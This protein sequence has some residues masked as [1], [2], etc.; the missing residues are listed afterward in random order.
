MDYRSCNALCC[1]HCSPVL[2]EKY[3]SLSGEE[4]MD[5]RNYNI[6]YIYGILFHIFYSIG[7]LIPFLV[8]IEFE[9]SRSPAPRNDCARYLR[10]SNK[11]GVEIFRPLLVASRISLKAVV[12]FAQTAST[13]FVQRC[14][15]RPSRLCGRF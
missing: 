6:C 1:C 2:A 13:W 10:L 5:N 8:T 3:K 7:A 11:I 12:S 9:V 15:R 14:R 4:K